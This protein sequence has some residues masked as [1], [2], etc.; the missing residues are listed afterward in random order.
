MDSDNNNVVLSLKS[1]Q[2]QGK[3]LRL[4]CSV[5]NYEWGRPGRDSQVAR[6]F[7]L[8]SGSEIESE[9]PYA[10]LWMGTHDSG[11]SFLVSNGENGVFFGSESVTLKSWISKNP[12]VLGE[13]V[14]E[15]WGCDL[16]FLFKVWFFLIHGNLG[17]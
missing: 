11:P 14:L 4:E 8:N 17:F 3:V 1:Q 13:K 6:L 15:K 12:N 7:A 5:K 9:K 2:Q 16:P 10:E